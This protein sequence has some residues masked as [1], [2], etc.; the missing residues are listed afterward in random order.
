MTL[1]NRSHCATVSRSSTVGLL[2][3]ERARE[4]GLL[5]EAL[6]SFSNSTWI[7]GLLPCK[8]VT[9]NGTQE[10]T[11]LYRHYSADGTLLY[12]GIAQNASWRQTAHAMRSGW[13][14]EVRRIEVSAPYRSRAEALAAEAAAIKTERP[15]FNQVH[16]PA[17]IEPPLAARV[18][19]KAFL[20]RLKRAHPDGDSDISARIDNALA[21]LADRG[22][23]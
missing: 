11:Q 9:A 12:V 23:P 3:A 21:V 2:L 14:R 22:A 13:F 16:H 10:M 1:A 7:C 4:G 19:G 18:T 17:P 8:S 5:R 15:R 6:K 20:R